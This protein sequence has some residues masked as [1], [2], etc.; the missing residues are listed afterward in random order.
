MVSVY[1]QNYLN[2]IKNINDNKQEK[3]NS[4]ASVIKVNNNFNNITFIE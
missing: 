4:S 2:T 3:K 1:K